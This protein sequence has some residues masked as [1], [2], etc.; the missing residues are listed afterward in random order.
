ML[1]RSSST[2]GALAGP[3]F[4]AALACAVAGSRLGAVTLWA[5]ALLALGMAAWSGAAQA[6]RWTPIAIAVCALAA[7]AALNTLLWSPAYTPAGLYH[8]LLLAASYVAVSRLGPAAER[9]VEASAAVV[10]GAIAVWGL[11]QVALTGEARAHALFETPATYGAFLNL[12]L[13][14]VLAAILI[15]ARGRL[16]LAGGVLL[17]AAAGA[18]HSRGSLL[19][20]A[21]GIGV[22]AILARRAGLLRL[23]PV[24]TVCAVA[25]LGWA[26][27]IGLRTSEALP[28]TQA[29]AESSL[30]RMELFALSWR[31]W[32]E[33]PLLGSGFHTF[34]YALEQQKESVPS[35][36]GSETWF[37]HNDYLQVLQELGP[38]GLVALLGVTALPLLLAYRRIGALPAKDQTATIAAG[39]ALAG[40]AAHA[41]VDFPFYIP[42]CL[43]LYGAW[44]GALDK[45][46]APAALPAPALPWVRPLRAG[47][48]TLA[49]VLLVK[50]VA[51]EAAAHWG[52]RQ[53]AAGSPQ[54]G[55]FWLEAARRLEPRDWRYHWYAGQFWDAQ[56]TSGNS[57]AARLAASAFAAGHE[58]NPLETRNLLG[59]TAVQ[60]RYRQLLEAERR[61]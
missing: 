30:S 12:V 26:L 51:A 48:W 29:R 60:R 1:G 21:A 54:S 35:Y 40:M 38:L 10:A 52:L 7:L 56:A 18:A 3:F 16:W 57:E 17:A 6:A 20:L 55:A 13:L 47:A 59:V 15:G 61:P 50:P 31:T 58:A 8:P 36:A 9:G 19:A 32:Q 14:P 46:L 42:A 11:A 22:A 5:L 28:D 2:K 25:A 34:R 33:H 4:F 23:R 27:A 43:L 49:A 53:S 41:A 45:R 39:S 24:L 44:L 37:V